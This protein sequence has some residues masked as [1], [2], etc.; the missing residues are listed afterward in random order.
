MS[1]LTFMQSIAEADNTDGVP[2][3]LLDFNL[4]NDKDKFIRSVALQLQEAREQALKI[5]T[6]VQKTCLDLE[7]IAAEWKMVLASKKEPE[8]KSVVPDF[9]LKLYLESFF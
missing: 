5:Q 6:A 7:G 3:E 1:K 9:A 8:Q 2:S 4:L